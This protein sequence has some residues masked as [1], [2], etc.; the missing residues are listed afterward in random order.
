M[1]SRVPLRLLCLASNLTQMGLYTSLR[2]G[3]G[4]HALVTEHILFLLLPTPPALH[5]QASRASASSTR[6]NSSL[7]EEETSKLDCYTITKIDV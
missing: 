7:E 5:I 4:Q 1:D 3:P 6:G 2:T